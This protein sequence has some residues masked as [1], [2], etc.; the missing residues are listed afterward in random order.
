[1]QQSNIFQDNYNSK[2]GLKKS[3]SFFIGVIFQLG[4]YKQDLCIYFRSYRYG[5]K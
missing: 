1:M 3:H 4:K 2:S 5:E